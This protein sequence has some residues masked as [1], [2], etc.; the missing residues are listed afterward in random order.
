VIP[1]A[2]PVLPNLGQVAKYLEKMDSSGTYSNFGP[3]VQNLESR[4]A[5]KLGVSPDRVVT[6]T[7]ATLAL[8]GCLSI[9]DRIEWICPDFTFAATAHAILNAG[10]S[11]TLVDV[12]ESNWQIDLSGLQSKSSQMGIVPVMPFGSSV[13]I[14]EFRNWQSVVIDAAASL[15][16]TIENISSMREEH[17]V[18]YSLHATK[19]LGAGEGALVICGT[20]DIAAELR[21]WSN[22]GFAG[23]RLAN[24]RGTNAKMSEVSAAYGLAS[25]DGLDQESY[26]WS[27]ALNMKNELL[28]ELGM[29]NHSDFYPGFRPYWIFDT[30]NLNSSQVS[31]Y[32]K[33]VGIDSRLWWSLPI[34]KMPGFRNQF[35]IFHEGIV[36]QALSNRLIGLP[37]W[38][39]ISRATLIKIVN[40]LQKAISS[41]N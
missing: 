16:S 24:R 13:D 2:K 3:L 20:S 37:M 35:K 1:V 38:R 26:E 33:N 15:G 14:N 12:C 30:R 18:V 8:E 22:F 39:G 40:S 9:L 31:M 41:I 4:Y 28:I 36:A 32:L 29:T 6:M 27:K 34:S 25:L 11:M 10:K 21:S 19:V 23:S 17:F 7:N 5:E